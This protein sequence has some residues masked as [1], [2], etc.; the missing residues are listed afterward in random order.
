MGEKAARAPIKLL[1]DNLRIIAEDEQVVAQAI[2]SDFADF[3]D[4]VQY[5][6]A[7]N[8]KADAIITRNIKDYKH[9]TLPVLTA[10]Q[11]LRSI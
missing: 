4:A 8:A 9:A 11:F 10:E 3:E 7:A 6:S 1:S 5:Y 2:V